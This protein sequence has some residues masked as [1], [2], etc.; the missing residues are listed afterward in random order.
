MDDTE[1]KQVVCGILRT[2]FAVEPELP[3][4]KARFQ[5]DLGLDSVE[6]ADVLAATQDEAG[7]ELDLSGLTSVDE[8]LSSG[9]ALAGVIMRSGRHPG[10]EE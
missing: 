8:M 6:V 1:I 2:R 4:D 10:D 7:I 3:T 9:G 5:K